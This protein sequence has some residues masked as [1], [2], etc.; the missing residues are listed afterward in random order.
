VSRE[1]DAAVGNPAEQAR[2]LGEE[3]FTRL[4]GEQFDEEAVAVVLATVPP[5][6][7]GEEPSAE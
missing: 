1:A 6:E 4:L 5:A 3:K 7:S 2:L